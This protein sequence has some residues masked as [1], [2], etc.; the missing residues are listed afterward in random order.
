MLTRVLTSKTK[1]LNIRLYG[2]ESILSVVYIKS[3]SDSKADKKTGTHM[4]SG[5]YGLGTKE[6][7]GDKS[8]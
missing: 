1:S 6:M 7:E 2:W 4:F 3:P 5:G 8:D